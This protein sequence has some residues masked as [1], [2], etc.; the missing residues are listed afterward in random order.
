MRTANH[1][2]ASV[3]ISH[4]DLKT[5]TLKSVSLTVHEDSELSIVE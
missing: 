5:K 1:D 2:F 4:V 3:S